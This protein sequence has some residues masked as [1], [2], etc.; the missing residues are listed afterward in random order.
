MAA[1][2]VQSIERTIE[3]LKAVAAGLQPQ[4]VSVVARE[5]G[6]PASTT[7]R[8][9]AAL[10]AAGMV[11]RLP[12][13]HLGVGVAT[14]DLANAARRH[15]EAGILWAVRP[16]MQWLT[17]QT[18]ETVILMMP[19]GG[20]AVCVDEIPSLHPVRL[21]Y[22]QG[23]AMPYFAGASNKVIL[24]YLDQ[25]HR[26]QILAGSDGRRL[27]TGGSVVRED[28]ERQL[29]EIRRTGHCVTEGEINPETIGVAVPLLHR[30]RVIAS[31]TVAGPSVRIRPQIQTHL[32]LLRQAV[33]RVEGAWD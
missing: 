1:T 17:Q 19:A 33:T 24:A 31:L 28:L 20:E 5:V 4:P 7:Y 32:R 23:R 26:D 15:S 3:V 30:S 12:D 13:G 25:R 6:L 29:E 8:L 22:E 10:E 27:I 21:S 18:H 11:Q 14:M 9:V 16:T 2:G